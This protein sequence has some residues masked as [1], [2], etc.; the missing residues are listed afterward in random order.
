MVNRMFSHIVCECLCMLKS[1]HFQPCDDVKCGFHEAIRA[2][3]A[4]V[5]LGAWRLV[6]SR[7]ASA[8]KNSFCGESMQ[9]TQSSCP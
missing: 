7:D 8:E 6:S 4:I 3:S 9:S 5:A 1:F 2:R